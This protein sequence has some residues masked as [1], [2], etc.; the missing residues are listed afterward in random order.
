MKSS[1]LCKQYMKKTIVKKRWFFG[2]Y[3]FA[4]T[5]HCVIIKLGVSI[6]SEPIILKKRQ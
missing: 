6:Y 4:N 1:T 3:Y 5:T 2:T